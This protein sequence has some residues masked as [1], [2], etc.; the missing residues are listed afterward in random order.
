M[1]PPHLL[2]NSTNLF[3]L[4][5]E[6]GTGVLGKHVIFAEAVLVQEEVDPLAGRQFPPRVLGL[7]PLL[8][9]AEQG[10]LPRLL[11]LIRH[12]DCMS[13]GARGPGPLKHSK[14]N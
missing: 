14:L 8:S 6:V 5:P 4:H 2:V 13:N 7:D 10:L 1:C 9:P 11:D 3:L 12:L